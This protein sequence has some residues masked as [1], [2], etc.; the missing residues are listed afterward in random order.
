MS[1]GEQLDREGF[2]DQRCLIR[3]SDPNFD[4]H[5]PSNAL[6]KIRQEGSRKADFAVGNADFVARFD[7][8]NFPGLFFKEGG[9]GAKG[10]GKILEEGIAGVLKH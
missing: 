10:D 1:L 7:R 8:I 3:L 6:D 4:I 9:I 2:P 5:V